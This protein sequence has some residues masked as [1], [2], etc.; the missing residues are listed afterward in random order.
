[1]FLDPGIL[2]PRRIFFPKCSSRSEI[3]ALIFASEQRENTIDV[4]SLPL[5]HVL[6]SSTLTSRV[7]QK[8]SKKTCNSFWKR[9]SLRTVFFL[10][11]QNN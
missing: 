3:S 4:S 9:G 2:M 11:E 7:S 6:E 10:S 8:M 5:A 1:M